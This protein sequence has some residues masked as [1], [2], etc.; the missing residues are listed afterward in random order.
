ME[1]PTIEGLGFD[2]R[3]REGL[4]KIRKI[5]ELSQVLATSISLGVFLNIFAGSNTAESAY[6]IYS[7][8]WQLFAQAMI[9][10]PAIQRRAIYNEAAMQAFDHMN[11]R[12]QHLFWKAVANGCQIR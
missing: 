6:N 11:Q 12:R 7:T 9:A 2:A 3:S 5:R 1:C 8:D 10:V 4:T